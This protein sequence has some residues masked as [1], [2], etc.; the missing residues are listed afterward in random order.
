MKLAASAAAAAASAA[1]DPAA[2][3]LRAG[4]AASAAA[5]A[6]FAAA[7]GRSALARVGYLPATRAS[8]FARYI[9]PAR[10]KKRSLAPRLSFSLRPLTASG[11]TLSAARAAMVTAISGLRPFSHASSEVRSSTSA[12]GCCGSS[13]SAG[14]CALIQALAAAGPLSHS[15]CGALAKASSYSSPREPPR[16]RCSYQS[17]QTSQLSSAGN[18]SSRLSTAR[19]THLGSRCIQSGA[20][21]SAR[22]GAR[23][24]SGCTASTSER[25]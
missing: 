21:R 18:A 25:I 24:S 10:F 19:R 3:T 23:A 20:L 16:K 12:G 8:A 22:A 9:A 14:R 5:P 17:N 4:T 1:A 15:S 7:A 13:G 11:A 6:A 2:P